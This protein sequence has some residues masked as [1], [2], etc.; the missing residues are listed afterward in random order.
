MFEMLQESKKQEGTYHV[1]YAPELIEI[2]AGDSKKADN[3]FGKRLATT[4]VDNLQLYINRVH[5]RFEE[6]QNRVRSAGD[7]CRTTKLQIRY[8][9]LLV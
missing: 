4:V 2:K 9:F 1:F 3:S 7:I 8:P 6:T 5:I